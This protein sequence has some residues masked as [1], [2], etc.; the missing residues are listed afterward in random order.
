M[1]T[2]SLVER[3]RA[4]CHHIGKSLGA[5]AKRLIKRIGALSDQV[6]QC[7]GALVHCLVECHCAL[8]NNGSQSIGA[9]RHRLVENDGTFCNRRLK[10][11]NALGQRGLESLRA[12]LHGVVQKGR[13]FRDR[14]FQG[15]Q[16]LGC[17][18]DDLRQATLLFCHALDKARYLFRD[19]RLSLMDLLSRFIGTRH[20]EFGELRATLRKTL[21]D[22]PAGI[23]DIA[24]NLCTNPLQG[25][26]HAL[27]IVGKRIALGG[28]L[29]DEV[30]DLELVFAVGP[31][32]SGNLVVDHSFELGGPA[33]CTRDGVIHSG[34]LP[35]D[36]LANRGNGLFRK[37]VGFGQAHG[38]LCHGRSHKSK[39]LGAPHEEGQEPEDNDR[40]EN[41]R[42]RR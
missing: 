12:I 28:Q 7:L 31:F 25:L 34:D 15:R 19:F 40:D 16:V 9:L 38:N 35:A 6:G 27:T 8:R 39:L 37:L 26:A 1:L 5:L 11:L 30:S 4:L 21:V 18:V 20:Q 29:V 42:C 13:L 10:P 3:Y 36:G 33:D 2:H 24:G 41:S 23:G 17:R 22:R 14:G 32:K